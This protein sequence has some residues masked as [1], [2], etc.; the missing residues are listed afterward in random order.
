[1]KKTEST[2]KRIYKTKKN[3]KQTLLQLMDKKP[4]DKISVSELCEEAATSRITFYNYY[5]DKYDLLD[6]I[7]N[8]L[9]AEM[10]AEFNKLQG[11]NNKTG[12]IRTSYHNLAVCFLN[13]F[14]QSAHFF[15]HVNPLDSPE[16]MK[17][18]YHFT[19]KHFSDF[20]M[21]YKGGK[22]D[23]YD[24]DQIS[25]FMIFG[26]WGFVTYG[27]QKNIPEE[28]WQQDVLR[29]YDEILDGLEDK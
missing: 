18:I 5:E 7:Y 25:A 17:S 28:K 15:H 14:S 9:Q 24:P 2:D 3:L 21:Q 22:I 6:D 1:M 12:D 10:E 19:V 13:M 29:L 23:R 11:E 4:F 16:I 20:R 26:F 27:K 8:D